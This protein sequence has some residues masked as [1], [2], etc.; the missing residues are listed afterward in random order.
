MKKITE[1][2]RKIKTTRGYVDEDGKRLHKKVVADVER[3]VRVISGGTRFAHFFV[4]LLCFEAI[5]Y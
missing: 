5:Y 2:T 1:L 4:D 3:K